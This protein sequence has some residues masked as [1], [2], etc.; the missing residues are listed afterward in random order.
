MNYKFICLS[1]LFGFAVSLF[2]QKKTPR[3]EVDFSKIQNST[4]LF[5]FGQSNSANHG[6]VQYPYTPKHDVF[7]Y[8]HGK[9]YKAKD[10][11]LGAT[12][13]GGS[14]WGIVGDKLIEAGISKAVTVVPIGVGGVA[15]SSWS[16]GG[17]SYK[18]LVNTVDA[19]LAKNVK[20][21][22]ICWHQG[23]TDNIINTPTETYIQRFLSIREVF[24]SRGIDAPIIVA[25][26]S[27]HPLCLDEDK[28][29]S[30]E[31][32]D[33]QKELAK[34]YDDIIKGPDTDKLNKLYQRADGIHFSKLGQREHA[35]LWVKSLRKAL[36]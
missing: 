21:D 32:R 19:L 7:N 23:E 30:D 28:G 1:V 17:S 27:Y 18:T 24:R 2:G 8:Y 33:A 22:A 26:A 13:N 35:D 20:I 5:T 6:Q 9:L 31:I 4:V 34:R 12:G 10:P 3:E 11:L 16:K 14:V 15:I 36:K 29:C 25:I